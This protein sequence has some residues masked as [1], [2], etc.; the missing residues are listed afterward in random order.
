MHMIYGSD[1]IQSIIYRT[2]DF[3]DFPTDEALWTCILH[4]AQIGN[5]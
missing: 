2:H 3:I 1:Q 5:C 4:L